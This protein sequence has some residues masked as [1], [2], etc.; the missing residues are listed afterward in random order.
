MIKTFADKQT[1]E[2]YVTG[3]SR[4]LPP[5]IARRA[6]RKLTALEPPN[7]SSTSECHPETG[8]MRLKAIA[9]VSTPSPST[10]SGGSAFG[11]RMATPTT[12]RYA[13]TTSDE[14]TKT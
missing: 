1:E 11:S 7:R 9:L 4:R 2:F 13:T 14:V 8:C 12:S 3:K 6:L 10:T 5:D